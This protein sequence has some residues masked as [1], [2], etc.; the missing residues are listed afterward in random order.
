MGRRAED[1]NGG[2]F[3]I[4]GFG[5]VDIRDEF[6]GVAIDQWEPSALDLDHQAMSLF[7]S[8]EDVQQFEVDLGWLA[9]NKR[10]WILE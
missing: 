9:G 1:L 5:E 4:F 6:L 8:M 3:E 10:L 2:L 7:K